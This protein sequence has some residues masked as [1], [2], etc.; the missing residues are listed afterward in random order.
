M[1]KPT[2]TKQFEY[3]QETKDRGVSGLPHPL[4]HQV[5]HLMQ[6]SITYINGMRPSSMSH[7]NTS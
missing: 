5:Y 7:R 6:G 2:A 3:Q 1:A 4:T